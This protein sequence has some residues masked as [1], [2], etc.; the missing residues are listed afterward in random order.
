MADFSTETDEVFGGDMNVADVWWVL[1]IQVGDGGF[2]GRA[3][4]SRLRLVRRGRKPIGTSGNFLWVK[5]QG[6]GSID[7]SPC[8]NGQGTGVVL[9]VCNCLVR[10]SMS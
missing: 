7:G 10:I 5:V 6:T 1:L 2:R 9:A 8:P 3:G 4:C